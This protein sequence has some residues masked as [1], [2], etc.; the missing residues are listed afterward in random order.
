MA[1]SQ[2]STVTYHAVSQDAAEA[3]IAAGMTSAKEI[4]SPISIAVVDPGGWLVSFRRMDKGVAGGVDGAIE[5][6]RSSAKFQSSLADFEKL[7]DK[8]SY[9]GNLPGLI[10]LGGAEP[11]TVDGEFV[12]AVAVSGATEDVEQKVAEAAAKHF[13]S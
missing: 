8:Q 3:V 2:N 5:K 10:P 7:A 12:G 11:L 6:A 1:N 9:I 13:N 4:G